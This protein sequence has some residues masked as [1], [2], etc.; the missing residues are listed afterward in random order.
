MGIRDPIIDSLE[1]SNWVSLTNKIHRP[2]IIP[3]KLHVNLCVGI[4]EEV[5]LAL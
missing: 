4:V 2:L 5:L 1:V 3:L